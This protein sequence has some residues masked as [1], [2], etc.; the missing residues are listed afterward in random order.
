RDAAR[1]RVRPQ[2]PLDADRRVPRDDPDPR[3]VPERDVHPLPL[4]GEPRVPPGRRSRERAHRGPRRRRD[5]RQ[6]G[7]PRPGA[8]VQQGRAEAEGAMRWLLRRLG[9]I[10]LGKL[11]RASALLTLLALGL[12]VWSMVQPTPLPV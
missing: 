7:L 8:P 5:V 12:M 11:L 3:A 2:L 6:R 9:G 10:D 4:D 1:L